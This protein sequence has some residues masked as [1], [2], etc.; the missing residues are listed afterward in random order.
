[1]SVN[2][3]K[4]RR[5]IDGFS[6]VVDAVPADKWSAPS[7]CDGWTAR[8]VVGHVIAGMRMMA[9]GE[10][11]GGP[12]GSALG[13]GEDP[14]EAYAEARAEILAALTEGNLARIVPGPVGEMPLDQ[15]I[16]MFGTSDVLIHTW[17]LAQTAGLAVTLDP[18]LVQETYDRL[19]PL[20]AMIRNPA[21]FGPKVEPAAGADV[22]VQLMC[23]TGRRA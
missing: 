5:A 7:P 14:V 22:Q 13:P 3:A 16:G 21:V 10:A 4:Y 17:D 15:I 20:D 12:A 8:D 19:V 1:M 9:R 2:A 23:F 6:A 11:G 18:E